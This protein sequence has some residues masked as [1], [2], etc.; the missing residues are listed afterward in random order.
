MPNG[1][2]LEK[3]DYNEAVRKEMRTKLGLE[4][5]FCSRTRRTI[6]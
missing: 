1:I 4:D 2:E 6:L 3:Y 5:R